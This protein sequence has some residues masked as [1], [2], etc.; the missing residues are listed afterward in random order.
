MR[1]VLV[2]S[3][4]DSDPVRHINPLFIQEIREAT[5]YDKDSFGDSCRSMVFFRP[6]SPNDFCRGIP[7]VTHAGNLLEEIEEAT[8]Q[9]ESK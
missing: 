8:R 3:P 7:C 9:F 4:Y 6:V 1:F 2:Q 5:Q